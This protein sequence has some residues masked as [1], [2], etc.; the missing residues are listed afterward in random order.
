MSNDEGMTKPSLLGSTGCQPVVAGNPAGNTFVTG[1]QNNTEITPSRQA[2]ETY[3]LAAC[4]PQNLQAR[5]GLTC[6]THY[7]A[8]AVSISSVYLPKRALLLHEAR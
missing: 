3:R 7:A 2:A 6:E 1:F 4:A 5:R 8:L